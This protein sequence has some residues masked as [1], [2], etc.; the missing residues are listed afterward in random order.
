TPP[1]HRG[2][3]SLLAVY[4]QAEAQSLLASPPAPSSSTPTAGSAN[5]QHRHLPPATP[6]ATPCNLRTAPTKVLAVALS[7]P[8]LLHTPR[9][10]L[11]PA[12]P[13][14]SHPQ[15]CGAAPATAHAR[16]R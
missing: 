6:A 16:L 7:L 3:S 12:A 14:T 4:G 5:S 8:V 1:S 10:G 15:R 9:P 11:A 2:S 13:A